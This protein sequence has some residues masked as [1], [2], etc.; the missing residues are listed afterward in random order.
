MTSYWGV[1]RE[2]RMKNILE[3]TFNRT[4]TRRRGQDTMCVFGVQMNMC[5]EDKPEA[6]RVTIPAL[7]GRR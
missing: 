4:F 5:V 6:P 1:R 3:D 2:E 7:P